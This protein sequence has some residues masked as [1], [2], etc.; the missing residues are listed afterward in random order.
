MFSSPNLVSAGNFEEVA[1]STAVELQKAREKFIIT[2]Q[3]KVFFSKAYDERVVKK[4]TE[5]R[6]SGILGHAVA[7]WVNVSGIETWSESDYEMT[8]IYSWT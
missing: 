1:P 5:G 7:W 2:L 4:L 3:D 6:S 8:W